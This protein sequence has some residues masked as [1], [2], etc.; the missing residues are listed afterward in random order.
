MANPNIS[1]IVTTTIQNRSGV[2]ADNMSKNNALLYQLKKK[3]RIKKFSGGDVILQELMYAENTN[4]QWYSGY[5]VLSTVA[6]DVLTSAQF[7][8][9]QAST[10][11]VMS[12]LERLQ[13]AS[14]E[15]I[16]DLAAARVQNAEMSIQNLIALG[17]Y[18]DGTANGGKQID[19]LAVAVPDDPTTGTYGGINRAT[20]SFWQSKKYSGLTDGGAAVSATN[21]QQYLTRLISLISLGTPEGKPDLAIGDNNYYNFL[22]ESMIPIQRVTNASMANAGFENIEFQGIPVVRDGN[23]GG[24]AGTNHMWLLNTNYIHYRPHSAR[25][26]VPEDQINS[27][28]QDATV[29]FILWA[30]N[31]TMSGS[32]YQGVLIA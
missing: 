25:E 12:G 27:I 29:Q 13:N 2:V 7:N 20:W 11:V 8:I 22:L 26:F 1:E 15:R 28:N 31:L 19:G 5:D 18:S 23:I 30:G 32:R 24:G 3:G 9:K 14:K 10:A 6:Q 4:T 16:I 17:L 21:I